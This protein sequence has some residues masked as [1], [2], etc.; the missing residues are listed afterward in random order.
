MNNYIL[1]IGGIAS[2]IGMVGM[3]IFIR[4]YYFYEIGKIFSTIFIT[5]ILLTG[6]G[7]FKN[8]EEAKEKQSDE[9]VE[10]IS[11]KIIEMEKTNE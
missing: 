2:F 9:K 5:G 4:S 6:L 11:T 3:I 8:I 1:L 7:V 10:N